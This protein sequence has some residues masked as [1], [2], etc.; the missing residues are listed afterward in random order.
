MVLAVI[1]RFMKLHYLGDDNGETKSNHDILSCYKGCLLGGA[2]GDALGYPVEFMSE[3]AIFGRYGEEGI[4]TLK[5]AGSP[6]LISD[7]TQMTLF[8]GNACI[9]RRSNTQS[10]MVT[11]SGL[12]RREIHDG[13]TEMAVK[14]GY[15]KMSVFTVSV[16]R[17]TLALTQ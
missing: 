1:K 14:C 4:K 3:A 13:L 6:A 10:G 9:Y 16:L 5:E 15:M 17:E 7:D 11:R 8:A 2:V 12:V